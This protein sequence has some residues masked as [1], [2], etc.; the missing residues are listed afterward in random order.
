M[1][2]DDFFVT[3]KIFSGD[4]KVIDKGRLSVLD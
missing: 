1:I 3:F 4:T 2:V